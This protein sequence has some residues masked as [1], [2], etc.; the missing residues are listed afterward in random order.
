MSRSTFTF[1]HELSAKRSEEVAIAFLEEK[2]L[3]QMITKAGERV[4]KKG[5]GILLNAQFLSLRYEDRKTTV[6]AWIQMG[7]GLIARSEADLYGV[8]AAL[9]K[10]QISKIIQELNTALQNAESD[11]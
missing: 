2:G 7:M 1:R 10:R 4:W 8:A 5:T 11:L 9:P 3:K 6:M